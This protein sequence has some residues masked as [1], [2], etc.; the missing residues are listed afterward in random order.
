[1]KLMLNQP[2]LFKMSVVGG[3]ADDELLLFET[4]VAATPDTSTLTAGD[5]VI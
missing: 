3:I 2:L 4:L 5:P 1:M